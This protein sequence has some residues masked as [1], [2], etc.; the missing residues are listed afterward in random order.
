MSAT[1]TW[2]PPVRDEKSAPFFEAA[3]RDELAIRRCRACAT[4]LAPEAVSC[5]A[6][7]RDDLD[8]T[9]ATGEA[10]LVTWTVV[11]RAPS[12]AFAELVP[13][14]VGVVEL[15]EGPWLYMRVEHDTPLR[16]DQPLRIEF[17]HVG[18][19]YPVARA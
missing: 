6:C 2:P 12:A 14:T 15:A 11:T 17:I 18:E 19:S 4:A 8:W 13:Y 10:R 9:T 1:A 5:T 3:A 16:S 7:G